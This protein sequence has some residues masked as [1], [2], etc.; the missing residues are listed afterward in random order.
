VTLNK[1]ILIGF[2]LIQSADIALG[3]PPQRA[4]LSAEQ[5]RTQMSQSLEKIESVS[6]KYRASAQINNDKGDYI[7]HELIMK[8][9][10]LF[11][12]FGGHGSAKSRWEDDPQQ[13]KTWVLSDGYF[14]EFVLARMY[15]FRPIGQ[16][17]P[18]P[19]TLKTELWFQATGLWP[20]RAREAPRAWNLMPM[21]NEV[22]T[23]VS[24]SIVRPMLE[25]VGDVWCNVLERD[26]GGD[27]LWLDSKRGCCL[28]KREVTE[29]VGRRLFGRVVLNQHT[30][31]IPGTWLPKQI[32][33]WE[34]QPSNGSELPT[35]DSVI[36]VLELNI[37]DASDHQFKFRP[38][39]GSYLIPATASETGRQSKPGGLDQLDNLVAWS[40]RVYGPSVQIRSYSQ[41]LSPYLFFLLTAFLLWV[42]E[43]RHRKFAKMPRDGTGRP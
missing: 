22:A 40:E 27:T 15:F 1:Q 7:Y 38:R 26:G 17:D 34:F 30:E 8:S 35:R 39:A 12:G 31:L 29:P 28:M 21:L 9:P 25:Q 16:T 19:G 11:Y 36:D 6:V 18:L 3:T 14:N 42:L 37:N 10:D 41:I 33:I 2:L 23:S 4:E 43:R 32:R 13:Q 5:L 24:Y 20:L